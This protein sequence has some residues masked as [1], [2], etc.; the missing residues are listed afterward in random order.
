LSGMTDQ[1]EDK[2]GDGKAEIKFLFSHVYHRVHLADQSQLS[3][4][5]GNGGVRLARGGV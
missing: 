4:I 2:Q 5:F 1:G 3:S